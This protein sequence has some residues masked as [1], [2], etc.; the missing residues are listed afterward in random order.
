[1]MTSV[2][3]LRIAVVRVESWMV[4]VH[5]RVA[6]RTSDGACGE[7]T[8]R[9]ERAESS[10]LDFSKSP[11]HGMCWCSKSTQFCHAHICRT[12]VQVCRIDSPARSNADRPSQD[13]VLRHGPL[14]SEYIDTV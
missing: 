3:E 5:E 10:V 4:K 8:Q 11:R 9:G 1:M 6:H 7:S 14:V 2:Q 13:L 12:S